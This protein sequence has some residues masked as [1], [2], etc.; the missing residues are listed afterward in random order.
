MID[1]LILIGVCAGLVIGALALAI[2][3]IKICV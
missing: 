3:A 1:L 2:I